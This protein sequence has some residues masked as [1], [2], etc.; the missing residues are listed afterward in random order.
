MKNKKYTWDYIDIEGDSHVR[1]RLA[2]K[3]DARRNTHSTI[4]EIIDE[5][6]KYGYS[7]KDILI[8]N[9]ALLTYIKD[10]F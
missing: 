7:N 8:S 5:V 4:R 2:T 6:S 3:K 10:I 1:I 9:E